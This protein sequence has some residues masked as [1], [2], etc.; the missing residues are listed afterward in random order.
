[1]AACGYRRGIGLEAKY[2][3]AALLIALGVGLLATAQRKLLKTPGPWIALV[4]AAC[5]LAP[6]IVWQVQHGG[7]SLQFLPSQAA[8]TA[9]DTSRPA[10]LVEQVLFL[11]AGLIVAI[12]GVVSLWRRPALRALAIVPIVVTMLFLFEQGRAYYPFPADS[13]AIAAGTVAIGGWLRTG[14]R[15]GIAVVVGLVVV[16]VAVMVV[17][18][19]VVVPVLPTA[20]MI[21]DK[22]W[23]PGFYDDEIGWP[24]LATQTARAWASL[25]DR[26]RRDGV[27]LA[28]NYGEASALELYGASRGLPQPLSGHLSWQYW[29]PAHLP[30]RFALTVGFSRAE[31]RRI[32]SS[33]RPISHIQNRWNL[34]NEERGALIASC[35]LHRPLGALWEAR[36]ATDNL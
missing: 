30:Q 27:L 23:K 10:Y 15:R 22:V 7:P 18:V 6:N 25:P 9:S 16:Q 12:V 28:R 5:L 1:M 11:G 34:A 32:C 4:V 13:I 14:R 2:T 20:T 3:I 36:I 33:V 21:K 26:D 35:R 31:L 17:T 29:R 24:E 8:K 19:P